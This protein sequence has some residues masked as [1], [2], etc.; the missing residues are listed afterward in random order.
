MLITKQIKP[1]RELMTIK[2]F[3]ALKLFLLTTTLASGVTRSEQT[4]FAIDQ[5]DIFNL[6][7]SSCTSLENISFQPRA[8]KTELGYE[9]VFEITN[10]SNSK[11]TCPEGVTWKFDNI[12]RHPTAKGTGFGGETVN[13]V[14]PVW[15]N[16]DGELVDEIEEQKKVD[17]FGLHN[18]YFAFFV[19]GKS[20]FQI[21][22]TDNE[23]DVRSFSLNTG[24]LSLAPA[25]NIEFEYTIVGGSKTKFSEQ[26]QYEYIKFHGYWHVLKI[27]F[28][29]IEHLFT[30]IFSIVSS[31]PLTILFMAI[32]V[33][34]VL[35]PISK[36]ADK[37]Q[38]QVAADQAKIQPELDRIKKEGKDAAERSEMTL[39]A[40]KDHG[41]S[42]FGG[43][44]GMIPLFIQ[45]PVFI[46]MYAIL[47]AEIGLLNTSWL[48]IADLSMPDQ[49]FSWG[50][51]LPFLGKY[52]NLVPVSMGVFSI[53]TGYMANE[54]SKAQLS[55]LIGMN[56][57]FVVM[58]YSFPSGV[59]LY[60]TLANVLH[61]GKTLILKF[62]K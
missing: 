43:L 52:F 46:S 12:F 41:M 57:M 11:I 50:I 33:K 37:I 29:A 53:V 5:S 44:K 40:Y 54:G 59:V 45:I 51:D 4:N 1:I 61:F 14:R 9:F 42:P 48:W 26:P 7:P 24:A 31:W 22:F 17:F 60:W 2:L 36:K 58:F 55:S 13:I 56:L 23:G 27:L 20:P 35:L 15:K 6:N 28:A 34:L 19:S 30:L 16:V 3:F 47:N 25:Q 21:S 49:L 38:K 8:N 39:K 62:M 10:T 32:I 18:R